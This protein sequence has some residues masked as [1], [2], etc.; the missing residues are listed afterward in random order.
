MEQE[1]APAPAPT[2]AND[3]PTEPFTAYGVNQG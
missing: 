1:N 3:K 2:E